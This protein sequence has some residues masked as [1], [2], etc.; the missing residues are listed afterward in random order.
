MYTSVV[1]TAFFCFVLLLFSLICMNVGF[2]EDEDLVYHVIHT[3]IL[4]VLGF[5]I[6]SAMIFLW[7]RQRVLFNHRLLNVAYSKF[8]KM[9]SFA[10]ILIILIGLLSALF[11][12]TIQSTYRS[13]PTGCMYIGRSY[14]IALGFVFLVTFFGQCTLLGS[15][16]YAP[17]KTKPPNVKNTGTQLPLSKVQNS[18]KS[19]INNVEID[20]NCSS[21]T[22]IS[23]VTNIET[24]HSNSRKRSLIKLLVR[25]TVAAAIFSIL[26][27]FLT[28]WLALLFRQFYRLRYVLLYD[29]NAFLNTVFLIFSFA[30]YKSM[31][32]SIC[33]ETDSLD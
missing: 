27:D 12:F 31:I 4:L 7:L 17:K 11:T 33:Y 22:N 10:S 1:V 5:N 8:T 28:P 29:I 26:I 20:N 2:T 24:H 30:D 21:S 14:K 32:F 16:V 23:S 13:S 19:A 6:F 18:N 9:L 3:V 25:R 15:F